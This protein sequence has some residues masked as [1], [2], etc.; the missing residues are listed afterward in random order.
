MSKKT[1]PFGPKPAN[2]PV[3]S[4]DQ[5]VRDRAEKKKR[6]TLEI[7]AD[8]HARIKADCARRG[9]SM[10]EEIKSILDERFPT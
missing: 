7:P 6:M 4:P 5:W 10:V 3:P 9:K 8:L 2:S 1:V